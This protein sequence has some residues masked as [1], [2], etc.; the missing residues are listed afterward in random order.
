MGTV[1]VDEESRGGTGAR[2][3]AAAD[4]STRNVGHLTTSRILH[5]K[6]PVN[7]PQSIKMSAWRSQFSFNKYLTIT[8][9]ATQKALKEEFKA[10]SASRSETNLRYQSWESGKAGEQTWVKSQEEHSEGKAA[11]LG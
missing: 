5:Q 2:D 10:K 1:V 3:G 7:Q 8:S 4:S 9:R 6:P 11:T